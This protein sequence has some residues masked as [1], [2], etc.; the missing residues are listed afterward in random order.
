M[1]PTRPSILEMRTTDNSCN[2]LIAVSIC[3]NKGVSYFDSGDGSCL[4]TEMKDP[5]A[6]SRILE[7]GKHD[8]ILVPNCNGAYVPAWVAFRLGKEGDNGGM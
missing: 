3:C 1:K 5:R 4:T 7:F 2:Q 8:E 6:R